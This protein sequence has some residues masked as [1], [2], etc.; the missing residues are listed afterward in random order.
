MQRQV[1]K[2]EQKTKTYGVDLGLTP[3]KN[4]TLHN[5]F[6]PNFGQSDYNKTILQNFN[7]K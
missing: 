7:I 2:R 3:F 5:P 1:S 6:G 4:G